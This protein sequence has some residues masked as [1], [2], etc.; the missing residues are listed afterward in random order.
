MIGAPTGGWSSAHI[1]GSNTFPSGL[2]DKVSFP[3]DTG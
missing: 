1:Y 3:V 2:L